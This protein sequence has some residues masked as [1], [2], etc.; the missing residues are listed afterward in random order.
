MCLFCY[1]KYAVHLIE[2]ILNYSVSIHGMYAITVKYVLYHLIYYYGQKDWNL[3]SF[4]SI[5]S[6]QIIFS[7][8]QN[9]IFTD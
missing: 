6:P 2:N 3:I 1:T 9:D 7:R 8:V 4:A 5:N